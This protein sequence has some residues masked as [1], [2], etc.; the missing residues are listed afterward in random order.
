VGK[1]HIKNSDNT[2]YTIKI[3]TKDNGG[4]REAEIYEHI[5]AIGSQHVGSKHVR[6]LH[7]AFELPGPHYCLVHNPL[8]MSVDEFQETFPDAQYPNIILKPLISCLLMALD[9]L[10]SEAGVIHTGTSN[11]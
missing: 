5:K 1:S 10:H 8:A 4:R 9:F 7:E 6:K 11:L 3:G 2:Y